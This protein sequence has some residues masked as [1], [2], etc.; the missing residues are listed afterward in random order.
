[1]STS[2]TPL[3]STWQTNIIFPPLTPHLTD[4]I[5]LQF[6]LIHNHTLQNPSTVNTT[7]N[8]TYLGLLYHGYD[9]SFVQDWAS[10][11]RGHSP[12]VW[13]RAVGWYMMAL[14]DV[15]NILDTTPALSPNS[16]TSTNS[17]LNLEPLRTTLLDYLDTL[18]NN[19][20]SAATQYSTNS[21]DVWWLVMTQPFRA[22]N[23]FESS[24]SAMYIY[25]ILRG[26]R[27]GYI[28]DSDGSK[29]D[30]LKRSYE[31]MV[32]NWVIPQSNGTM[33]W[34][35][36]VIVGSLQPGNDYEVSFLVYCSNG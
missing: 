10:P 32:E 11:D 28:D 26:I 20:I 13:D 19:L 16:T 22:G 33:D 25:A 17:T 31:Y 30:V 36:T 1:V 5:L 6:T 23:Y 27:L 29:V 4:D 3:F 7:I 35:N 9:N 12:E 18:T 2:S 15:L 8:E 14:V 24:G 21:S 34:N